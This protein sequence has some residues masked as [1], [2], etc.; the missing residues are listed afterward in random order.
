M[1]PNNK[2]GILLRVSSKVQETDG[3]S[4]DVQ[5]DMGIK[6]S[7]NL[8]FNHTIF[9]EGS[10][11]SYRVEINER[12]KL[13]ELLEGIQKKKDPIRRVWVFNTDRLGRYSQSWYTILK[14]FLDYSVELYVGESLKPYDFNN[15]NDKLS[16]GILSLVSQYDNEL[17]RLRSVMGKR[18]S[19]RSGN[20]FVGGTIPFGYSLKGKMLIPNIG[21]SEV[22]NKI[23]K[24][25]RDGKSSTEI[26]TFLDIKTEYEPK[27]SKDGWNLGTIQ[28]MLGNTLYKGF[29][30]WDWKERIGGEIKIVESIKIKTPKIIPNKLWEEVQLKLIKNQK[31]KSNVD[32]YKSLF[33]GVLH[34]KSCSVRLS[35]QNKKPHPLYFCRSGEYKWK[36]PSKWGSKHE[37]CS[38]KKGLRVIPTDEKILNH[39]IN[40]IKDSKKVREDYKV[41]NLSHKFEDIESVQKERSKRSKD[42]SE[43]RKYLKSL[44]EE[45]IDLEFRIISKQESE[46]RG[47]KISKKLSDLIEKIE[48]EIKT[49][50]REISV[51]SNST[52]WIDWLNQMYLEI[53][54]VEKLSLEK[55]RTFLD[56]YIEKVEVE[57]LK[58]IQSHQFDLEFKYPIVEDEII[59]KGLKK[60]GKR[61]YQ[62]K[63]GS[64]KTSVTIPYTETRGKTKISKEEKQE[65]DRM[66]SDLRIGKSLSLNEV[67]NE[68]NKL[69]ITTPTKKVWDKP[70]LS[71]YIKHMKMDVGK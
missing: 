29:Q 64:R 19:L 48:G 1:K 52:Q 40:V 30:V 51:F 47:K 4:L 43:S 67:C 36:N 69:E 10:Q 14:V 70:K 28:K 66:I 63:K 27:R 68:L 58:D 45:L 12:I 46:V 38:L 57:Y 35:S 5:K 41:K 8:G 21:E 6:L 31:T 15:P 54:S 33:K 26:K 16:I 7:K 65:L 71:S 37:S 42:L 53:D 62:I 60:D 59:L 17:R 23:F 49:K 3:T 18:N 32:T 34:C 13:V 39:I 61:N 56:Q 44:E 24:M 22:L 25:Y 55:Q 9:N 2:I 50:E 20:T 11:S